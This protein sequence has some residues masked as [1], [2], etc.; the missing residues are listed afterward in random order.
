[1]SAQPVELLADCINCRLESGV[2]E[3]YDPTHPAC[4][5]GLPRATRCRL[6]ERSSV[7][8]VIVGTH[9]VRDDLRAVLAHACPCCEKPL[10]PSALDSQS[11][12]ACGATA[13]V[14]V[15][16]EGA[17]LRERAE[18]D[19][20]LVGWAEFENYASIEDLVEATFVKTDVAEI[21]HA[22]T[23]GERIEAV[24]DPFAMGG[25]STSGQEKPPRS[26]RGTRS[27]GPPVSARSAE[28]ARARSGGDP[29]ASQVLAMTAPPPYKSQASP[30]STRDPVAHRPPPPSAPPRA[31]VYPLVSVI[32]ADGELNPRER[33]IVDRFLVSE[34]LPPLED[35]EFCVH[36]P[37]VVA[38]Y[39]PESRREDVLKLM[40]E[41]AAI[42]GMP[43]DSEI[44]VIRAFA[45]AWRVPDDKVNLWLWGYENIHASS[46]RLFWL[47]IRR[48]VLSSRWENTSW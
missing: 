10:P 26:E 46:A 16:F 14:R 38:R 12:D 28:I 17:R 32:A 3:V 34:G 8:E 43:D 13:A 48:F 37:T 4:R 27:G 23:N 42:D 39:I 41:T 20:A 33:E 18:L 7:G 31:I 9:A 19:R 44:R 6:C 2:V 22:L 5:F 25:R 29:V 40:C 36:D 35:T 1:M 11:C 30:P 47:R 15:V 45:A 21:L 24:A